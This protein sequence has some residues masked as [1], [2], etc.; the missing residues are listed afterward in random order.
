MVKWYYGH[1]QNGHFD[2]DHLEIWR[3]SGHGHGRTPLPPFINVR[4]WILII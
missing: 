2:Y 1:G 4:F 3:F